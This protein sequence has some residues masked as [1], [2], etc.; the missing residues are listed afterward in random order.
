[1]LRNRNHKFP[2]ADRP[3]YR[4]CYDHGTGTTGDP[5]QNNPAQIHIQHGSNQYRTRCG[6]DESVS[7][8]QTGEKRNH[9]I[10]RRTFCTFCQRK[11]QGDQYDQT[12]IKKHRHGNNKAGDAES[13]CCF[14]ISEFFHHS[15]RKSLGTAGCFQDGTEHG[16]Q[17]DQ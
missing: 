5:D 12:G 15:N 4:S 11:C 10:Q 6:R 7:Y 1:M 14:F 17:T 8:R 16:S 9:I 3:P 13:P 2:A